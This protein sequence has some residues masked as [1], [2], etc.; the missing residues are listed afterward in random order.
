MLGFAVKYIEVNFD[1]KLNLTKATLFITL[2]YHQITTYLE[3]VT[4]SQAKNKFSLNI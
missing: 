2:G 3:S 1:M 4:R